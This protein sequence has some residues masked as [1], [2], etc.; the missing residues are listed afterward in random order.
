MQPTFDQRVVTKFKPYGTVLVLFAPSFESTC[1]TIS[2]T[3]H[4][5]WHG[6]AT[7]I[8]NVLRRNRAEFKLFIA[9]LEP[10]TSPSGLLA[11]RL[12]CKSYSI[13]N[14]P[15]GPVIAEKCHAAFSGV[16]S[17]VRRSFAAATT[18]QQN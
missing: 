13:V 14:S 16:F 7:Q 6:V 15:A 12:S 17:R 2:D 9:D 10:L 3:T 18:E 11:A 8:Y 1:R 4:G 5:W